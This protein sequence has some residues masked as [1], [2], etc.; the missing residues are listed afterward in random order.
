M[1]KQDIEVP[2]HLPFLQAICWQTDD[3][4]HFTPDEMLCRYE[5][6]WDYRGVLGDLGQQERE[7]LKKLAM[8]Y[9]SW[10]WLDI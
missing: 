1:A 3:V 5:R 2:E 7:F 6:G 10:L 9:K 8:K 4:H